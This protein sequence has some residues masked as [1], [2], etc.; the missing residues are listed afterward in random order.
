[1]TSAF[2]HHQHLYDNTERRYSTGSSQRNPRLANMRR[3]KRLEYFED[4]SEGS[5]ARTSSDE[6]ETPTRTTPKTSP[7]ISLQP[8]HIADNNNNNNNSHEQHHNNKSSRKNSTFSSVKKKITSTF[9]RRH[10]V[11]LHAPSQ[12]IHKAPP[13][14]RSSTADHSAQR[15]PPIQRQASF[16]DPQSMAQNKRKASLRRTAAIAASR[17]LSEQ[18]NQ[19][20]ASNPMLDRI[21]HQKTQFQLE[22][23]SSTPNISS[24]NSMPSKT[25]N[26]HLLGCTSVGK[27][28]Q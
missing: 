15:P 9:Q 7:T 12:N 3:R 14:R 22:A 20:T 2:F 1:M 26:I 16:D 8:K 10:S 6:C 5:D 17:L 25:F 21:L 28:G 24:A 11:A 23:C 19:M 13:L 27:T 4:T 18:Q